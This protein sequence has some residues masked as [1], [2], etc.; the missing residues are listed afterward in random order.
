DKHIANHIDSDANNDGIADDPQR[1]FVIVVQ[2]DIDQCDTLIE[3][4][5]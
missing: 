1:D 4:N 5:L 2:A 3:T